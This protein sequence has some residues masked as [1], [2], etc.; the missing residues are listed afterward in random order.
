MR[1][2]ASDKGG[3]LAGRLFGR[4]VL[5]LP[6]VVAVAVVSGLLI[7]GTASAHQWSCW[8]WHRGGSA[9][10]IYSYN[11]TSTYWPSEY[12]R[13]DIHYRPHPVYLTPVGYHTDQSFLDGYFGATGWVGLAQ[14]MNYSGCHIL[15]AHATLNRSYGY[16]SA[17]SQGVQCQ[18]IA[19]TLGLQ[20]NSLGDCMGLGYYASS[21][22]RYCF[23]TTGSTPNCDYSNSHEAQDLYNMYRYHT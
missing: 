9:V 5:L 6:L 4:R 1:R 13:R 23:G 7:A 17:A 14:I 20:H 15:H 21:N 18:E 3:P 16:S 8:H 22:G 19:H 11:Q 2:R 12:A 10:Y